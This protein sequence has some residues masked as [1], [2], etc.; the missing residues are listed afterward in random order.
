MPR[1]RQTQTGPKSR[2]RDNARPRGRP[3]HCQRQSYNT[4]DRPR[5]RQRQKTE[6]TEEKTGANWK[7]QSKNRE[8]AGKKQQHMK[9]H[10]R[11]IIPEFS[12]CKQLNQL[13]PISWNNFFLTL[14]RFKEVSFHFLI[15][16]K[17]PITSLAFGDP[18]IMRRRIHSTPLVFYH[19]NALF[20][21]SKPKHL[22]KYPKAIKL[23]HAEKKK[24]LS[25]LKHRSDFEI[26]Q[27]RTVTLFYQFFPHLL[28]KSHPY[29]IKSVN[30]NPSRISHF[31]QKNLK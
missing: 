26:S 17:N 23:T 14:S 7:K 28:N 10:S 27:P 30:R 31:S 29:P 16:I 3:S 21:S 20:P 18:T 6:Q 19:P 5:Q 2:V 13:I 4:K 15:H 8:K 1:Q 22:K 25:G 24:I 9:T 11:T 12:P